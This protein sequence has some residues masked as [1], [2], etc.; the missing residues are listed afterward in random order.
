[1]V[2]SPSSH[3]VP[4]EAMP[5]KVCVTIGVTVSSAVIVAADARSSCVVV[6]IVLIMMMTVS[7]RVS[8]RSGKEEIAHAY[9]TAADGL[10]LRSLRLSLHRALY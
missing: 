4:S 6:G 9:S 1:M 2:S 5:A 7:F 3:I 10:G 8:S